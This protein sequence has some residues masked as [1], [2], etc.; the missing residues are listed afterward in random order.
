VVYKKIGRM[1]AL[2]SCAR[3]SMQGPYEIETMEMVRSA[4]KLGRNFVRK[5]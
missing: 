2:Y 5:E 3:D 4:L 1:K